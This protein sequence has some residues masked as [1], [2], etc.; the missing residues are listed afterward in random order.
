MRLFKPLKL[1]TGVLV[2]AALSAVLTFLV[3]IPTLQNRFVKWD[4]HL[5]IYENHLIR[6]RFNIEFLKRVFFSPQVS[7]WHPLTMISYAVDYRL[8]GLNPFGYHLE[9]VI[10][11]SF[12]TFL[13]AILSARLYSLAKTGPDDRGAAFSALVAA[14]LFGLHPLH[15]ESV[16]WA[17]ERK[18]ALCGFF[19]I[20]SIIAYLD[21]AHVN[22]NEGRGASSYF[23][24][25]SFFILAL[26]SL[27]AA[28][29]SESAFSYRF[30]I[31]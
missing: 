10:L 11:H 28:L 17:S 4:D 16:S 7:N 27:T 15:V 23:L 24:S 13:V 5:Y 6:T 8:W 22:K 2:A 30:C 14:L 9:N 3:Y 18:D 25:L 20:L 21:Y 31:V 26:M 1:K 12:N 29:K 19:F